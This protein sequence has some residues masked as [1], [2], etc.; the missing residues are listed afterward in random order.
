MGTP[1]TLGPRP[2]RTGPG[3]GE[4]TSCSLSHAHLTVG[5]AARLAAPPFWDWEPSRAAGDISFAG[6]EPG[7]D[8]WRRECGCRPCCLLPKAPPHNAPPTYARP[9]LR[10]RLRLPCKPI[11]SDSTLFSGLPVLPSLVS[12]SP[13]HSPPFDPLF[14]IERPRPLR[15]QATPT[16]RRQA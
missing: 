2:V 12:V 11:T 10:P 3:E 7:D 9:A 15:T 4:E 14:P 16:S 8:I 6:S 1:R 13:L 5:T